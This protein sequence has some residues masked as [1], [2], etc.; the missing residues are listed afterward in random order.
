MPVPAGPTGL[1][2]FVANGLAL[3]GCVLLWGSVAMSAA[4]GRVELPQGGESRAPSS[5]CNLQPCLRESTEQV[6]DGWGKRF[7][8]GQLVHLLRGPPLLCDQ[9]AYHSGSF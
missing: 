3:L 2:A 1:S 7:T 5:C 9:T 8:V 6:Q 4:P